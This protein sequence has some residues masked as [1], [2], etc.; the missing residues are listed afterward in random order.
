LGNNIKSI[1]LLCLTLCISTL[2]STLLSFS[3]RAQEITPIIWGGGG[4]FTGVSSYKDHLYLSSDVSGVWKQRN[5]SW[6]PYL[7]GLSQYNVSALAT[8]NNLLFAITTDELLYTDGQG[9]W[10][11]TNIKLDT[12][13]SATDKPYTV[14][15]EQGLMCI[16]SLSNKIQCVD[17]DLNEISIPLE[18]KTITGVMFPEGKG[19][20]LYFYSNNKL[21]TLNVATKETKLLAEYEKKV[22]GLIEYENS[23]LVATSKKIYDLQ[24]PDKAI[25]SA[26][27]KNIINIFTTNTPNKT[28]IFL[29]IGA[30]KW[31]IK[32]H[33]LIFENKAYIDSIKVDVGL[34]LS[35]PH[36][37]EQTALTKFLSVQQIESD[38]Y[39]TD[40]WGVFIL[41]KQAKPKL[42]EI[43]NNAYNIVATDLVVADKY[44]YI[45]TMDNGVIKIDKTATESTIRTQKAISFNSIKGH[46]WSMMYRNKTLSTIFS[47]WDKAN[48]YIFNYSEVNNAKTTSKLTHY[49]SRPDRGAF[50]GESYSR[51]LVYFHGFLSFRDGEKGGLVANK[52][53]TLN[54]KK[55][56]VLGEL[57]RVYR[58]IAE[59]NG[60][61]YIANCENPATIVALNK[62]AEEEFSIRSPAGFCAFTAYKH[63]NSLYFLGT[64]AGRAIINKLVGKEVV[65]YADMKV[66][67]AFYA[68]AI[69]PLNDQQIAIATISW[70]TKSNSGLFVSNNGGED[71]VDKSCLLT[72]EN[73]VAAIDFD[74]NAARVYILQK[75]GGLIAMPIATLFSSNTCSKAGK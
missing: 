24:R 33:Q 3:V 4:A 27:S 41:S 42:L 53:N 17:Q 49:N 40:Y 54:I 12:K 15:G 22:I 72:Y 29:G 30:N 51:Q 9:S 16:A 38:I 20:N 73:G 74:I 63:G 2:A 64:N 45:S 10:Y 75:V 44:L 7:D 11:S 28:T 69:N 35:L 62:A 19:N 46:A 13:R 21:L 70:S 1:F 36:R 34:D 56:Y 61:L 58:A 67:S 37:I 18:E 14:S 60:L 68:M 71:F 43:T 32:L 48:V 39:L 5:G 66:G 6:E 50:W 31:N 59:L 26:S 57:N 52:P 65:K 23:I 55:P 8:F 25:Y 47:P